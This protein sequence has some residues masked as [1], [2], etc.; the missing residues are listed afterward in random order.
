MTNWNDRTPLEKEAEAARDFLSGCLYD[1][2]DKKII[3]LAEKA[4]EIYNHKKKK[5][6]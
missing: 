1:F 5:E 4:L 3:W 2:S 6:K